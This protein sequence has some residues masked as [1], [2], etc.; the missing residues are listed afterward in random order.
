MNRPFHYARTSSTVLV[1]G[2]ILSCG[3]SCS[4]LGQTSSAERVTADVLPAKAK[5]LALLV[6]CTSYPSLRPKQQLKGPKNDLRLMRRVLTAS[7]H[8]FP[9]ENV[10]CLSEEPEDHG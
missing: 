3:V 9:A 1:V 10:H 2:T 4:V 6:G 8:N 7:P 5:Q